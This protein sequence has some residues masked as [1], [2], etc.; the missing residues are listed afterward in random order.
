MLHSRMEEWAWR[1][2]DS[3]WQQQ[4]EVKVRTHPAISGMRPQALASPCVGA[5]LHCAQLP[6]GDRFCPLR[7]P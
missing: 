6:A 3:S 2:G 5:S 4:K 1:A 7:R